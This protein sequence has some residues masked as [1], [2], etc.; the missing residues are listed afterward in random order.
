MNQIQKFVHPVFGELPVMVNDG[1]EWFGAVDAARVLSF[2]DPHKA[3]VN[4]VEEDD[5]TVH[6][7]IDNLGRTQQKKFLNESGLYSLI[8]GAAKQGNNPEIKDKAKMFKRWVTTD[9]LPS[10]RKHGAYL[11]ESTLEKALSS[12]D[13][14]IELATKL[15][16]EQQARIQAENKLEKQKPLVTFAEACMISQ[17]SLLVRE[18]A[19]LITN[20]HG[21]VIGEKRLYQKLR[22]WGLVMKGRTEPKQKVMDAGY[23][24]INHGVRQT[25]SGSFTYSTTRVTPKGQAYI[26]DRLIREMKE[27]AS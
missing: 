1:V 3:I 10:I 22:D 21:I 18:L 8:F 6:P 19:K 20:K 15:K 7:V 16:N 5:S 4:H 27:D 26:I 14:L 2:S 9:V 17:N 24:E 12:P 25:N 13:F 11:T 23:F